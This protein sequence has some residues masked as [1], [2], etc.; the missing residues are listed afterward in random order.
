MNRKVCIGKT[1]YSKIT[2]KANIIFTCEHASPRIPKYLKNLGVSKSDLENCKDIYDPGAKNIFDLFRKKYKTSYIY[3]NISRLVIDMNRHIN[4]VNKHSNT[5]HAALVKRT[6]LVE[7]KGSEK[8][9]DIPH[10]VNI[11]H[12]EEEML[13]SKICV[14]YQKDLKK[15]I[16]RLKMKHE[17]VFV[18]SIHTM[19]PTYNG[20]LRK[21][22]IDIMGDV[23]D[24][25]FKKVV[26]SFLKANEYEIGI[27]EPWGFKDVDNGVFF[28]AVKMEG[29]YVMGFEIRNDLVKTDKQI[30]K[31]FQQINNHIMKF[32]SEST[33]SLTLGYEPRKYPQHTV[34]PDTVQ[35]K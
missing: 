27:N 14:P 4:A 30:K 9:V 5:F 19:F 20:P 12:Q 32:C 13:Y 7:K 33:K 31:V 10:N 1:H 26:E 18:I 25:H 11:T 29:V 22:E 35:K 8:F 15:I 3:S 16:T 21:Q 34:Q 6:I 24:T 17:K 2:P 23:Q 28:E